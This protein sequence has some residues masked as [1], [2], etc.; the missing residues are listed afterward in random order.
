MSCLL[1]QSKN[2]RS[3]IKRILTSIFR[4]HGAFD[5]PRQDIIANS[6]AL[7]EMSR[8]AFTL[9]DRS[10]TVVQ[11]PFDLTVSFAHLLARGRPE[12]NKFFSFGTIYRASD[13][14]LE[15]ALRSEVNFDIVSSNTIDLS[16]KDAEA[17]K[18][19]DEF[20]CSTPAISFKKPVI[21]LN[22]SDLL[23]VI[24]ES[25]RIAPERFAIVKA[26]LS[27]LGVEWQKERLRDELRKKS[28][29]IPNMSV[30][31]LLRFN[32]RKSIEA[33]RDEIEKLL[34]RTPYLERAQQTLTRLTE[35]SSYLKQ[36]NVQTKVVIGPLSNH[37]AQLYHGSLMFQ[38]LETAGRQVLAIGGRYD[39]FIR[40]L[41]PSAGSGQS[42]SCWI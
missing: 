20:V 18:T 4:R 11:L 34:Q 21:V 16:L 25:S 2:A 3:Y 5:V 35:I 23:D 7:V 14:K 22:H 28:M 31:D 12:N 29:N 6:E 40:K 27:K 32:F 37:T 17:I 10:G 38:C 8:G 13:E 36:F 39:D 24:L 9:L 42:P 26:Q 41:G 30:E 33:T 1:S 19:L 15:P